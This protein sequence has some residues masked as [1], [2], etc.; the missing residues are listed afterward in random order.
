MPAKPAAM[1]RLRH[2]HAVA[3]HNDHF[4]GGGKNRGG[5][6]RRGA[7][8]G[9][10]LLHARGGGLNLSEAAEQHVGERAIHGFGHDD[11]EN[12]AARAVER[13]GDN[14][15]LAVQHEAHGRG[16][17]TG[18]G[19]QQRNHRGHVRAADGND[20]H[21]AENQRNED[22]GGKQFDLLRMHGENRGDGYGQ[23]QHAEVDEVL[24]FIRDGALRQNFLQ[25]AGGHQAAGEGE[26]AENHF[27]G[28]HGHQERRN[29]GRAQVKLRGADERDAQRAERVAERGP[30]RHGGHLHFAERHADD[31]AE[32][33]TDG[34]Q[35]VVDDAFVEQRAADGQG[36]AYFTGPHAVARGGGRAQP[37]QRQNKKYGGDEVGDLNEGFRGHYGLFGPLDLNMRSMRSVIRKPPTMLL[38]AATMAMVPRIA[39]S[40][41]LCSPARMM[42]PTTAMA[43]S[44]LV[45]DISGVCSSGETRRMTSKPM[46]AASMK[47][48]RLVM[49]SS[50]I[51]FSSKIEK[52]KEPAALRG[53]G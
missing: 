46:K 4:V 10:L 50:F 19:V 27:H 21:D 14:Q 43:S 11:G 3:G 2:G 48:Y 34:H 8:D 18:V 7:L 9:A 33:Q 44:A 17:K 38:V 32:H 41:L 40:W 23:R 35:L 24:S 51:Y 26:R 20:Q 47:T 53:S 31:A 5:F 36:H 12:E 22:H 1:L 39:A 15:Q 37:L 16:G 28:K 42:A 29:V 52:T 25:L 49:R 6:F 45:R 30:L 13:T